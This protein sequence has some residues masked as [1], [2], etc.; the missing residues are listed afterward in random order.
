MY[1]GHNHKMETMHFFFFSGDK[2]EL[3]D[4]NSSKSTDFHVINDSAFFTIFLNGSMDAGWMIQITGIVMFVLH[5]RWLGAR[6]IL[7]PAL[8]IFR[9]QG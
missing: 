8:H 3:T 5:V 6:T 2:I 1:H 9:L 7:L 4:Q